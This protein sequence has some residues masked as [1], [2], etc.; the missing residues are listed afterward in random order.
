[1]YNII[2]DVIKIYVEFHNKKFNVY[3]TIFFKYITLIRTT[4]KNIILY[5]VFLGLRI[6]CTGHSFSRIRNDLFRRRQRNMLTLVRHHNE[7]HRTI[8]A[9]GTW[10]RRPF[11]THLDPCRVATSSQQSQVVLYH[12]GTLGRRRRCLADANER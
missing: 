8:S 10:L 12:I 7:I 6:V 4:F 5:I 3:T 1:M 11:D 2:Y 9:D